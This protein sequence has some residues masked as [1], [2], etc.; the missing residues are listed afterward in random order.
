MRGIAVAPG[1]LEILQENGKS[2]LSRKINARMHK[3]YKIQREDRPSSLSHESAGTIFQV[4]ITRKSAN[5]FGTYNLPDTISLLLHCF[6]ILCTSIFAFTDYFERECLFK[7]AA[8]VAQSLHYY[9]RSFIITMHAKKRYY[10]LS[11]AN[12]ILANS[13]HLEVAEETCSS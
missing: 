4:E 2:A 7:Y 11:G 12:E 1:T 8:I 3:D 9:L 6:L 13:E 10:D 5:A